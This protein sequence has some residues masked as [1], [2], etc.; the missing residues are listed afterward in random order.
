MKEDFV[1]L[2][3]ATGTRLWE[4]ASERGIKKDAVWNYNLTCP[5]IVVQVGEEYAAAGSKILCANTFSANGMSVSRE[6]EFTVEAVVRSGVELAKAAAAKTGARVAVDV[7]PL[8]AL[9]QPYGTLSASE[10]A[11]LFHVQISAGVSAGA[12]LIF[13]ETFMDIEMLKLAAAEARKFDVPL[14]CSMSFA[15]RRRTMMGNT[16]AQIVEELE[17][18]APDGMGIN[19][20]SGPVEAAEV[21]RE[22]A[23]ITDRP[24]I[25]KPNAGT[26]VAASDGTEAAPYTAEIFAAETKPALPLA[27]YVGAC[28]GSDASYIKALNALVGA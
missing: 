3:G 19:C 4:L 14:L 24:L 2:D 6:S 9:L 18:F 13:L 21:L 25:F 12:D 7:G 27:T 26:P 22:Y 11:E 15:K 17:P 8:T 23:Q 28:C 10:A 1:L 5:E 20:S 16:V